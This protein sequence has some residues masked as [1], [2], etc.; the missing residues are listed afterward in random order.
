M[1]RIPAELGT[2][3]SLHRAPHERMTPQAARQVTLRLPE[4]LYAQVKRMARTRRVSINRLMRERLE[5][6]AQEAMA[7]E[8]RQAYD[9]LGHATNYTVEAANYVAIQADTI[10]REAA[11]AAGNA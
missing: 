3:G 9:A 5:S 4:L 8:L 10:R 6:L 11:L 7:H 1:S 2:V